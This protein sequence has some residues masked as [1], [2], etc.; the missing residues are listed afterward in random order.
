VCQLWRLEYETGPQT[1]HNRDGTEKENTN[2]WHIRLIV[3]ATTEKEKGQGGQRG[4]S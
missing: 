3:A 4:R 1:L 2:G